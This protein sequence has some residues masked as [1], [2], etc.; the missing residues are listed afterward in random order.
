[1]KVD[2]QQA[3]VDVTEG[4]IYLAFTVRNVG[5]GMA[6]L[7]RWDLSLG[8]PRG[9][10][11]HRSPDTFTRLTRDIYV[12][13][14]DTGFWQGAYRDPTAPEFVAL[15]ETI[16]ANGPFV[17]DLLYGDVEGGQH[18]ISRFSLMPTGDDRW[19]T[20]VARHWHLD[21]DDPR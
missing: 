5:A 18:A 3:A 10:A 4:A 9:D 11:D 17:V 16:E 13:P 7:D 20:V 19:L 21:A 12:P 6:V 15:R 14:G 8:Q 2:G 1:M